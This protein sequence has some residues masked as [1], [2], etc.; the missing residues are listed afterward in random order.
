[1]E[2]FGMK[3]ALFS[4]L[5]PILVYLLEMITRLHFHAKEIDVCVLGIY[6]YT[7]CKTLPQR[8]LVRLTA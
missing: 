4:P 1:M 7:F 6:L 5:I 8:I 3:N 2:L